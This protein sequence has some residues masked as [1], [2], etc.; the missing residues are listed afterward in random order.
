MSAE[1][2]SAGSYTPKTHWLQYADYG[3]APKC[4]KRN[5]LYMVISDILNAVN[6]L[7][8]MNIGLTA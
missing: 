1:A 5:G 8:V 3:L 4:R 6:T 7:A 2:E